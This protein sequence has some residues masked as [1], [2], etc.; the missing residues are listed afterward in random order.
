MNAVADIPG[1]LPRQ[2]IAGV[3]AP[4]AGPVPAAANELI[5]SVRTCSRCSPR[6]ARIVAAHGVWVAHVTPPG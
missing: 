1:Y 4:D 3:R 2:R 5:R 6:R